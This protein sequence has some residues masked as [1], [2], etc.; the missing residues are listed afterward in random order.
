MDLD[1]LY[2]RCVESW[3]TRVAAVGSDQWEGPT[4]CRDW[5]VRDL[6]NHVVGEDL[7]TVP[8]VLGDTIEQVG[9]RFD[10]DLVGDDPAGAALAAARA[11]TA[12]VAERLPGGGTV[13]LSYGEERMAEYVCQLAADHLVHGWDLAVATGGDPR[14]DPALVDEVAVWFAE[15]EHLYRQAGMLGP[16]VVGPGGPQAQLLGAFGRDPEWGPQHAL[17]AMFSAAFGRGDVEAITAL[18]HDE[19]VFES[20][21]PPDGERVEGAEALREVWRGL[22][23]GTPGASFVEE[24]SWVRGDRGVLQWR[25]SWVG[26]DGAEG[27]VRGVDLLRFRDGKVVAKQSYVKG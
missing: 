4:P 6:V 21:T 1:T 16:R 2:R 17:L 11:A 15:R 3:A 12:C 13:H 9:D 10:G 7:W 18:T 24:D 22:F 8:L 27:H 23:E 5:S 25:Y 19:C 20:T 14:L 26:E